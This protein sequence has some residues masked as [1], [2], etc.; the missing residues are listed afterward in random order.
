M[1]VALLRHPRANR[2]VRGVFERSQ[3][4]AFCGH[5]FDP[6]R[7]EQKFVVELLVDGVIAG[8]A[9]AHDAVEAL[10]DQDIGDGCYG[11]SFALD[12]A[13]LDGMSVVEARLANL[14]DPVG[15]P[16]RV[17]AAETGAGVSIAPVGAVQWLGGL[18][19]AAWVD[20]PADT[21]AVMVDGE[22][23][24]DV[25]PTGWSHVGSEQAPR[26][27]RAFDLHLPERFAD[28]AAHRLVARTGQGHH[29][30][31]APLPFIAFAD[32]L[33]HTLSGAGPGDALRADLFDRLLPRSIP[34][35]DYARW[36]SAAPSPHLGQADS[37]V[38]VVVAGGQG[39][40]ATHA[41]LEGQDH[42]HWI[43]AAHADGAAGA[44]FDPTAVGTF[45]SDDAADSEAVVFMPAG[46][47]LAPDAL[48]RLAAALRADPEAIAVYGDLDLT[49]VDGTKWP[50]AFP[51]FDYERMLEQG[52]C[53][54]VFALRRDIAAEVVA[55]GAGSLFRAFNAVLDADRSRSGRILH[56]P[57]AVATL[58]ALD[59]PAL[60]L[61][62]AAATADH[63]HRRDMAADV[64]TAHGR[65]LPAVRV[66]REAASQRISVIIPTRNRADLL[67]RC[68]DSIRPALSGRDVE[69]L[70]IDNDSTEVDARDYLARI[71]GRGARVIHVPGPFNFARLNNLAAAEAQ[72]DLLCLLN[73][74][75]EAL[76]A[77]W[78]E[79]LL[80]RLADPDVGA[81]GAALLRPSGVV[82]HG[83]LV[84]GPNFSAAHAFTDRMG[85]DGG[86]ADL[87]LVARECSA[88]TAACLLTRRQDYL[89]VGGLD[90]DRFPVNYNDVD[91]CLK[92]RARGKS[93]VFTPHARLRHVES[94]SRGS[95]TAAGQLPRHARELRALRAKW[96]AVLAEDPCYSPVLSL[97][98]VPYSALAWPTRAM[99]ARSSALP[100]ARPL[101]PGF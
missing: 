42:V 67:K 49:M 65:V 43:A 1:S 55:A 14:G 70:V 2:V 19:F 62:L 7:L 60:T 10:V 39:V 37:M 92:L 6:T 48:A 21:L 78:L 23:V 61:E 94:A 53:S 96:S 87:M 72:G 66:R 101:P 83:G 95:D 90:A 85:D 75:I 89:A 63:L 100:M 29:L 58:P 82:Q 17:D 22:W 40:D 35:A 76:D 45:F 59:L 32:S 98:P 99:A 57:G 68:I 41:S 79:E 52:Y 81:A 26:A 16:I 11:F 20:D 64:E 24:A 88:V 4:T 18:R 51:A 84:L 27:V 13:V 77:T 31:G 50:L 30:E 71:D 15:A 97:D 44:I 93:V 80:G 38:A 46:A 12:P 9:V 47:E 3:A 73:N 34:F 28:G 56:L 25:H 69:L 36:R 74:D 86:Y 5:V 33:A 54:L 91:Y 8:A